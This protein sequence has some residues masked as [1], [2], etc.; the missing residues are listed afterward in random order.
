LYRSPDVE[1]QYLLFKGKPLKQIILLVGR[2]SEL[3]ALITL[4]LT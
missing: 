2:L 3:F 4:F 1:N